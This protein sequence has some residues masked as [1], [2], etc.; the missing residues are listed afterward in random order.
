MSLGDRWGVETPSLSPWASGAEVAWANAV[1]GIVPGAAQMATQATG[2]G[3]NYIDKLLQLAQAY[4]TTDAQRRLLSVQVERARA[5][6]PP[7][8]MSQYGVGVNVGLSPDS[9]RMVGF[10]IVGLGALAFFAS[11]RR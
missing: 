1:D 9:L 11:R 10:A 4:V 5:G 6:Q 8:D 2:P 3:D 7:L